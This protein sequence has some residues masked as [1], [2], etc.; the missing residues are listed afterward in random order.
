MSGA[1][2]LMTTHFHIGVYEL[3]VSEKVQVTTIPLRDIARQVLPTFAVRFPEF[4]EVCFPSSNVYW[5]PVS[6]VAAVP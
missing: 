5:S 1:F 2:A 3:A 4:I 6:L